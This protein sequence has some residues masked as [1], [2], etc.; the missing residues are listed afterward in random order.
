MGRGDAILVVGDQGRGHNR[1]SREHPQRPRPIVSAP[2]HSRTPGGGTT[3][4][5]RSYTTALP[6]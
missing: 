4:A 1:N 3:P 5:G 6:S 2:L